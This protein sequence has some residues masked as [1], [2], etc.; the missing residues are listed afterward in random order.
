QMKNLEIDKDL[1]TTLLEEVAVIDKMITGVI[2]AES[3]YY[4]LAK[5]IPLNWKADDAFQLERN[6]ESLTQ[7]DLFVEAQM[8]AS[9]ANN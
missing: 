5:L 1:R 4:Y 2:P 7:N 8:I 9:A 3:L 6:L